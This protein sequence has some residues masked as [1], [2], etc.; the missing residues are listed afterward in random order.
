[1]PLWQGRWHAAVRHVFKAAAEALQHMQST[2]Q[3]DHTLG[4]QCCQQTKQKHAALR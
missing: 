1:M 3:Q 4:I 2:A